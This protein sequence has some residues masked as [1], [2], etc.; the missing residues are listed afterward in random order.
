MRNPRRFITVLCVAA[1]TIALGAVAANAAPSAA[2]PAAAPSMASGGYTAVTPTR[3]LD[4]RGDPDGAFGPHQTRAVSVIGMGTPAV[5]AGASAVVLTV[6]ALH[7][8]SGGFV[9]AFADG[10]VRPGVSNVNYRAGQTVPNLV[11]AQVGSDGK[12]ALYNGSGGTVDLLVDLSGYVAGGAI[13]SG[14]QGGIG[15]VTPSRLLNATPVGG[16]GAVD[17]AVAGKAGVPASATAAILNVTATNGR[18]A[19]FVTAY[20]TG[21]DLPATS[22]LNYAPG[23]TVPNLVLVRLG[24]LGKVRLYNGSAGSVQLLAD[25]Q[26]YVTAGDPVMAGG[27]GSLTPARVV[28]TRQPNQGGALAPH[29][30]RTIAVGGLGG[31]PRRGVGA[32]VLNVT[33]TRGTRNGYLTVFSGASRP[34]ASNVNFVAGQTVGSLVVA[35]VSATGLVQVYNG[36]GGTVDVVA[37]VAGWVNLAA[38]TV[39]ATQVSHYL[40]NLVNDR[41][42]NLARMNDEGCAD[43]TAGDTF[44]LLD[45]GAQSYH[46]PLS[47]GNPGVAIALTSGPVRFNYHELVLAIDSY[48][49]GFTGCA[50][51]RDVTVAVGTNNSGNFTDSSDPKNPIYDAQTRGTDWANQV[52]DALR[53]QAQGIS[54][55][56][57]VVG[58]ID[59]EN[60]DP[61][62]DGFDNSFTRALNWETKYLD[63]A[64]LKTLIYNGSANGCPTAYG[65]GTASTACNDRWRLGDF[66][67]LTKHTGVQVL[68]QVYFTALATQWANIDRVAGGTLQFQGSLTTQDSLT[69][70]LTGPQG[71]AGLHHSIGTVVNA[72]SIPTAIDIEPATAAG[73]R[74]VHARAVA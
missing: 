21:G 57:T 28:D 63:A 5:P 24:D 74:L 41:A 12:V 52:V 15:P 17:V 56:L 36:S 18:H 55:H 20:P 34:T 70:S 45:V 66:V 7:G 14:T 26:G 49:R 38:L 50:P 23:R 2:S 32:V 37:D 46:T 59:I 9:T 51:G 69:D 1:T 54:P 39:P 68:P 67:E 35:P 31:V 62:A 3:V 73:A 29:S 43:G 27:L 25:V 30:T 44:V 33:A 22:N 71:W 53:G 6:T 47:K 48:M 72:P 65:S 13:P 19:G 8:T 16:D 58:A 64:D 60:G 10:T 61:N 4:T 40:D 11:L 42:T